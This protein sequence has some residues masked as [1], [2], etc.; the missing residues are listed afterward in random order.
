MPITQLP[1]APSRAD[2]ANF[3][4]RA[5]AW[6]GA[7]DQFTS[8]ANALQTD[9]NAKQVTASNAATTATTKASEASTSATNAATSATNAATSA[10]NALNSANAAAASYDSFDDRYLGSKTTNPTVDNDGNTLLVGAIYWNSVANE[11][12]VWNGSAWNATYLPA[13]G[14]LIKTSNLSDLNNAASA[15]TNLGLGTGATATVT[16]S[17]TDTTD[18]RLLK[19]GDFGNG[20]VT[21]ASDSDA[22]AG[23]YVIAGNQFL[24]TLGGN[25]FPPVSDR[26]FVHVISTGTVGIR[27]LFVSRSAGRIFSRTRINSDTWLPW[28]EVYHQG[29]ILGTV[30]QSSGVPT[31]AVIERGSN[32]NGEYVR[33]ADG[34]QICCVDSTFSTANPVTWTF[35]ASFSSVHYAAADVSFSVAPGFYYVGAYVSSNSLIIHKF[36]RSDQTATA[37]NF[38][39]R[40]TA[41]GRWF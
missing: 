22:N 27:Q 41:I 39:I 11:M 14:Y 3:S 31:G 33:F 16:T 18:G 8:E 25:N 37:D 40:A 38:L 21:I 28:R 20:G 2:P 29:S 12:R 7:L 19:V 36:R 32:A 5:D 9:V 15:R 10:T 23:S 17:A 26:F 13:G 4:V 24:S 1:Q 6:V 30:S 35:P 34:T